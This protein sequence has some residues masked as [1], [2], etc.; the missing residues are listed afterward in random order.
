MKTEFQFNKVLGVP[1]LCVRKI[2][3]RINLLAT[4][5]TDYLLVSGRKYTIE[6][7]M[8]DLKKIFDVG[9]L[10]LDGKLKL[11]GCG[12]LWDED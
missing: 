7:Y 11:K 4:H 5:V 3:A 2:G 9:N 8:D 1:Q 6:A 12:I 10:C